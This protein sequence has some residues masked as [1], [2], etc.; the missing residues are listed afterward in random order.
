AWSLRPFI[1]SPNIKTSFFR[2]G[3]WTNAYVDAVQ[4]MMMAL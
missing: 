2:E 1:G 3:S 4:A